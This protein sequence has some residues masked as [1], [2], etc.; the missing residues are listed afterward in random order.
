MLMY[1][2][3]V[4]IQLKLVECLYEQRIYSLI[5]SHQKH[6]S[7]NFND[8]HFSQASIKKIGFKYLILLVWLRN[9]TFAI[10]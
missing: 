8:D 6:S 3:K 5:Y 4:W 9:T 10:L 7:L 1:C 2:V